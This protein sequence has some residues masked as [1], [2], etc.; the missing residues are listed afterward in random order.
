MEIHLIE[1]EPYCIYHI[2]SSG[3]FIM[4][5]GLQ[6][7]NVEPDSKD[8]QQSSP[9]KQDKHRLQYGSPNRRKPHGVRREKLRT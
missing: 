3:H 6:K 7:W 8:G 4:F 5:Y 1:A 9:R 2:C